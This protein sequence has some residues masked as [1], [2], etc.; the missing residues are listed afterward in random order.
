M[1]A[2]EQEEASFQLISALGTIY[3]DRFNSAEALYRAVV[4]IGN[5]LWLDNK[6][7][8]SVKDLAQALDIKSAMSKCRSNKSG[9]E[10]IKEA[11]VECDKLLS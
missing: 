3:V 10:K 9:F 2:E 11:T 8:G 1:E 5:F 7:S 6:K 4:A